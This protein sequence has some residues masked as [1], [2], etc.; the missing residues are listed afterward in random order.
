V[1][2]DMAL[3]VMGRPDLQHSTMCWAAHSAV[4]IGVAATCRISP[5]I[6]RTTKKTYSVR[7]R[8]VSTQKNHL[9]PGQFLLCPART[10]NLGRG[11]PVTA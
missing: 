5:L 2:A 7:N 4:G 9:H 11:A 3:R 6:C 8:M 10:P 1:N